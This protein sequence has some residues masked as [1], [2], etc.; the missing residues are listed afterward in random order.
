MNRNFSFYIIVLLIFGSLIWLILNKGE[1]QNLTLL[2]QHN[3][4]E[5]V[6]SNK[7]VADNT[8][9]G[10]STSVISNTLNT[11][12]K[13]LS[14]PLGILL[15]QIIIIVIFSRILGLAIGKLGQPIVIGEIIAGI[16]LGPSL[17]GS[18]F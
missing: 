16:I 17:L 13:Q 7:T 8:N 1:K 4:T 18:I 12:K 5:S 14:A 9:N 10:N 6:I 3:K 15:V 2:A 11:L